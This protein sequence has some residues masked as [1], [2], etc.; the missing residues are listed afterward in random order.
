MTLNTILILIII[1]LLIAIGFLAYK[2]YEFSMIIL[3][4]EDSIE[5]SLDILNERYRS[6][7]EVLQKPVFFDSIEVRQVIN[8]IKKS[9]QAIL[10]IARLLTKDTGELINAESEEEDSQG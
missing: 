5:S 3:N 2:L 6:M 4:I 10:Q 8:D 9:H 1:L 7:F